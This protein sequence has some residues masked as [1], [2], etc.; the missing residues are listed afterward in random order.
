M[1]RRITSAAVSAHL[2]QYSRAARPRALFPFHNEDGSTLTEYQ[3]FAIYIKG[4]RCSLRMFII[5]RRHHSQAIERRK[6]CRR[7]RRIRSAD[8]N[9]VQHPRLDHCPPKSDCIG[10]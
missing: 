10:P 1:R 5:V 8:K 3:A 4:P 2:G 7:K 6:Q 9:R